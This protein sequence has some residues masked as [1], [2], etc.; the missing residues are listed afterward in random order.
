MRLQDGSENLVALLNLVRSEYWWFIFLTQAPIHDNYQLS[1]RKRVLFIVRSHALWRGR[2]SEFGP[3][4][5]PYHVHL[6]DHSTHVGFS[7]FLLCYTVLTRASQLETAVHG[8]RILLILGLVSIMSLS[9]FLC[10][11]ISLTEIW[12]IYITHYITLFG[13]KPTFLFF[14]RIKRLVEYWLVI[15]LGNAPC[16]P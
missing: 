12:V 9:C 14:L 11:A 7:T 4:R 8:C 13:L 15:F 1:S 3:M 6:V 5:N 16:Y 10:S 2:M